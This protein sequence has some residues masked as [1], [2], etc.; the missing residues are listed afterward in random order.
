M[1]KK[2]EKEIDRAEV[3]RIGAT[4]RLSFESGKRHNFEGFKEVVEFIN[5][6]RV[7]IYPP[8][9]VPEVFSKL[10]DVELILKA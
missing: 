4:I 9:G 3:S 6:H 8:I 2:K 7:P 5:R 10:I 1:E